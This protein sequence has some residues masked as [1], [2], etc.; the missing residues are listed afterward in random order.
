MNI[1]V[2]KDYDIFDRKRTKRKVSEKISDVLYMFLYSCVCLILI[3]VILYV[4]MFIMIAFKNKNG[5]GHIYIVTIGRYYMLSRKES[6]ECLSFDC[7]SRDIE[8]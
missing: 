4:L 3:N 5:I 6:D 8:K 1:K 2:T 7:Y